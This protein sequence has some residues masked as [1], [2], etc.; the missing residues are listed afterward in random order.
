MMPLAGSCLSSIVAWSREM[1]EIHQ[2]C[3]D[4]KVENCDRP[5][6]RNGERDGCYIDLNDIDFKDL[7]HSDGYGGVYNGKIKVGPKKSG[8]KVHI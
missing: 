2:I 5:M 3:S 6:H 7:T 8:R 1:A 4:V